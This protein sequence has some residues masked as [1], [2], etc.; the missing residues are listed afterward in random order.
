MPM[1]RMSRFILIILATMA[2][3]ACGS[4]RPIHYY[5]MEL[6][7]APAPARSAYPV[8]VLIGRISAPEILQDEPIVYRSGPNEIGTYPYHQWAEPPAQMVKDMLIRRLR[9]SGEYRS[10]AE[11]GSSV[12]GDYVLQGRLYDFEEDDTSSITVLVSMELELLDRRSRETVWTHYYSERTP[13]KGKEIS[14][15]V[16]A[17]DHNLAED[18][19]EVASGLDAYFSANLHRKS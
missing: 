8:T 2:I 11:L 5:T 4:G 12:Q 16:S 9:A 7:P 19:T 15:V 3:G 18:L 13:V 17:L 14:D 1:R 6:P 10:V